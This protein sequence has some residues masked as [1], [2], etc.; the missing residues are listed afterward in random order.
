VTALL[1]YIDLFAR[2]LLAVFDDIIIPY[3][4]LPENLVKCK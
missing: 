1:G 4:M 3:V 2:F